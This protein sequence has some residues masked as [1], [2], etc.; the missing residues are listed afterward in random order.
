MPW[1]Y[2]VKEESTGTTWEAYILTD[3]E[4]KEITEVSK[5]AKDAENGV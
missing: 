4:G 2:V 3:E 5:S 1:I